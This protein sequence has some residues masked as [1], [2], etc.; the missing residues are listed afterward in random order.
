MLVRDFDYDLPPELI[1]QTP[2]S[3]R[4]AA[5]LLHLQRDNGALSHRVFSELPALLRDDDL[6]IFNDTRVLRARLRGHKIGENGQAGARVE[7]LLLREK[8]PNLWEVLLRPSARLKVGTPL[9]FLSP[10]ETVRVRA[11]PLQ[12]DEES[13]LLQFSPENEG[14]VRQFLAHL[15]EVPLPPYI[16]ARTSSES[17]Y[18]TVYAR[19]QS[20]SSTRN[21]A[22]NPVLESAAAPTAG[23]HFTPQ[24][25]KNL[26]ARGV[27]SCFVTLGIGIGTFRPMKTKN[28]EE[29]VMHREEYEVSRLAAQ[30]IN[31]QKAR[32]G[33]AIAVG[34]TTV[35][36]LESASDDSG[37]VQSGWNQTEIFIRPGHK[38]RVVDGLITNFHLP[39]S[40]LMV[41]ISAFAQSKNRDGL[42]LVRAAYELAVRERYRFFSFG[43]AMFIE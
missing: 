37:T 39:R 21:D 1:A 5:R 38:F 41:M 18:Q 9:I 24:L 26:R 2:A 16:S 42:P 14:D 7:A 15:G 35:R 33:R 11:T 30:K 22:E 28:L 3:P 32:G 20:E 31:A 4:D 8:E 43:D 34:T 6:L 27:E 13:W 25:L 29:H 17:D 23:L 10:D 12:R 36:V 40:S 19:S